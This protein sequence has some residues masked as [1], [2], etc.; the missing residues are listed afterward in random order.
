MT[1]FLFRRKFV[2]FFCSALLPA[3]LCAQTGKGYGETTTHTVQ[4]TN[5]TAACSKAGYGFESG[6]FCGDAFAGFWDRSSPPGPTLPLT[7]PHDPPVSGIWNISKGRGT[8][9]GD[10]HSLLYP[11]NSTL[12]LAETQFWWCFGEDASVSNPTVTVDGQ[13]FFVN[14]T[15]PIDN[16]PRAFWSS[17]LVIGY[18]SNDQ[19]KTDAIAEDLWERG[20]DGIVGDWSGDSNTCKTGTGSYTNNQ[21]FYGPCATIVTATD[22]SYKKFATSAEV[23]H[24]DL[25]IALMYDESAYKFT[26]CNVADTYQPQCIQNKIIADSGVLMTNWFTKPNYLRWNGQPVVTFFIAENAI[27]FSQCNGNDAN[28]NPIQCHL[29]GNYMCHGGTACWSSLWDGVRTNFVNHGVDPYL[30]FE[31]NPNHEQAD[32]NFSWVEPSGGATPTT[33]D[34]QNN[35]GTQAYLDSQLSAAAAMLSSGA[36]GGNGQPKTY[37]AGAWKG[38][39]DR[40][41]S[42]SPSWAN[43]APVPAPVSAP[44]YPRT[45]SQRCGNNWMDTFAEVNKYFSP[46]FQLPFL[47]VGTW[48]DYE[49]GTEIETGIDN[50]VSSLN[51][52]VNGRVLSWSISFTAPGSERTIDHYTIFY[53]L[54]GNT[55]EEIR[56]LTEVAVDPGRNGNYSL[57]LR[58]YTGFLPKQAVLYVDAVGRPS[59]ANHMSAAVI[60]HP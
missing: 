26:Q 51:A 30:I 55:G 24:P 39:D 29:T 59:M 32:G 3:A 28:G 35:W 5:N 4:T 45:T 21:P 58:R 27:N 53:S 60:Y 7:Q 6:P 10:V 36:I 47:M 25:K 16:Q 15:C 57:N 19:N 18:D 12:I 11:G 23:L 31:S 22:E 1:V 56:P 52:S 9:S 2:T 38:F 41:A 20:F 43:G 8:P 46:K 48:D 44:H 50:C 14:Q 49:E 54:D 13:T 42:W 37:F 33:A 34:V 17:H 40:M